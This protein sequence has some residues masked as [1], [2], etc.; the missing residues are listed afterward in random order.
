M[1]NNIFQRYLYKLSAINVEYIKYNTTT[2]TQNANWGW[3][4]SSVY[5]TIKEAVQINLTS[6]NIGYIEKKV[7]EF[8]AFFL[9]IKK[10]YNRV[11]QKK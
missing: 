11:M 6:I 9:S 2:K 1:L 7:V 8:T 10:L 3:G 5:I 4:S